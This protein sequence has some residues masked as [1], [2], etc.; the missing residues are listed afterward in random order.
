[1]EF[2][3]IKQ[4]V[5]APGLL[6]A[7]PE[8]RGCIPG[9][10]TVA[11]KLAARPRQAGAPRRGGGLRRP[12]SAPL[13]RPAGYVARNGAQRAIAHHERRR[14]LYARWIDIDRALVLEPGR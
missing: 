4:R 3:V 12:A 13:R 5:S 1:V 14:C 9:V 11:A 8:L 10:D 6:V 7:Y 2:G